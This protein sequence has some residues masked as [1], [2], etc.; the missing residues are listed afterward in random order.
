MKQG[1]LEEITSIDFNA[2]VSG[3]GEEGFGNLILCKGKISAKS[4]NS[5]SIHSAIQYC[6]LYKVSWE[7][8]S[9]SAFS[10]LLFKKQKLKKGDSKTG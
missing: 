6:H 7:Y 3:R 10:T 4:L 5:M 9:S 2:I 8:F 1:P